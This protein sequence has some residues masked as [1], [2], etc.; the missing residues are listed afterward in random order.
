MRSR[1]P[2]APLRGLARVVLEAALL[3]GLEAVR[4]AAVAPALERRVRAVGPP[5]LCAF[6]RA[7]LEKRHESASI[8]MQ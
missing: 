4:A 8:R 5:R 6:G 3:A 2:Q 1:S 7:E